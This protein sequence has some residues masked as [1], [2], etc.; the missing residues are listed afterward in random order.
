MALTWNSVSV[1]NFSGANN[2][3]ALAVEQLSKA[4]TGLQ[5][6]AKDYQTTV[7]NRNL[8]LI[9][10]YV[11][12]A[13][14]PEELQSEAFQ[15]GLAKLTG[16]MGGEYDTLAKAQLVDKA[17]DS[18]LSRK[19]NQVSVARNEFGLDQ[20]KLTAK[21]KENAAKLYALRNDQ[22]AYKAQEVIS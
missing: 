19:A 6:T 17:Y 22:L 13:K 18:L 21:I 14:S 20:D 2:L 16:S 4:G 1:P 11:N 12:S 15:T 7:R 10:D 3:I 5:Q 9:Q 8:G